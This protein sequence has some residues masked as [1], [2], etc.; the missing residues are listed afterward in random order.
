MSQET[1]TKW[2]EM[3]SGHLGHIQGTDRNRNADRIIRSM[4]SKIPG[5]S[6]W[7]FPGF[8]SMDEGAG[9]PGTLTC[10]QGSC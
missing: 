3:I 5:G 8:V 6:Q 2:M 1:W 10:C 4:E 9:V 7:I